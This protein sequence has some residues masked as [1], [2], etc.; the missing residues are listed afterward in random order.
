MSSHTIHFKNEGDVA[1]AILDRLH[2]IL[3]SFALWTEDQQRGAAAAFTEDL[4]TRKAVCFFIRKREGCSTV[5]SIL[6]PDKI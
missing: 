6:L 2:E 3:P 5:E 4:L 1:K